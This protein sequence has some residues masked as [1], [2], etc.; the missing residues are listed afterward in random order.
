M[1]TPPKCGHFWSVPSGVHKSRFYCVLPDVA[2]IA[3]FNLGPVPPLVMTN[4]KRDKLTN[5]KWFL[6]HISPDND[7]FVTCHDK[8]KIDKYHANFD[9][10]QEI[11]STRKNAFDKTSLDLWEK[12]ANL[13]YGKSVCQCADKS[14]FQSL[15]LKKVR[16][17]FVEFDEKAV[18]FIFCSSC[19]EENEFT[20]R[21][22][23]GR[24]PVQ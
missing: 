15:Y 8:R 14:R 7:K 4:D 13:T 6:F 11:C 12:R 1:W 22:P 5:D 9:K 23:S 2:E 10:W 16:W 20:A 19:D 21:S 3:H 17:N 18:P 24:R